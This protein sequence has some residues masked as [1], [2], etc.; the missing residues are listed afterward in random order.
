MS[1]DFDV[2]LVDP[3]PIPSA[4]P[5]F[6]DAVGQATWPPSTSTLIT[7]DDGALLVDC[8]ITAQEGR[9]LATWVRSHDCEPEY[10]YITH[11]HAD[12]FLGLT[13]ILAAFPQA[14][15]VALAESIP[16]MREQISPGY[17]RVWGGFFPGQLTGEPVAP[18]PL[19]GTTI[20]VGG[21]VATLIPVG[22]TDTGHSSVVHVPGLSLVISGDVVYNQT[23][24]WLAGSTPDSRASWAH[25][26]DAV[27]ALQADTLI[28]GHRN[29]SAPDDDARRQ[30][31][32]SRRY[33]SDFE[34]ALD[35]S[36]TPAELIDRM[37]ATHPDL[38]NPYTLWVA[39][40]D[41][42]GDRA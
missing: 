38:A 33:L 26:L 32:D 17:M 11:P 19:T 42:L 1:L 31:A 30:I 25:A 12:H 28:A 7:G 4:V 18:A 8:L 35:R 9:E 29:P 10:V 15:P 23:H 20:P 3:K 5:G 41:L 34:A 21:S 27:A 14:R 16:A 39:A 36:S 2:F 40:H 13:E 6:E 24:M 22:T 37:T